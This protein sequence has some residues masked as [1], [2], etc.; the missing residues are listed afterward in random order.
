MTEEELKERLSVVQGQKEALLTSLNEHTALAQQA[1]DKAL[2][3]DGYMLALKE[4]MEAPEDSASE[5]SPPS[6]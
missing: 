6:S 5:E 3:A 4:L 2:M 1:K